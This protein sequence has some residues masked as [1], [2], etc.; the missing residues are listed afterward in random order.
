MQKPQNNR[1]V[2]TDWAAGPPQLLAVML[3]LA[4]LLGWLWECRAA[5]PGHPGRVTT[6]VPVLF[7]VASAAS[8]LL[9]TSF[10]RLVRR[11]V[12]GC[13]R[14]GEALR[15]SC[16]EL[17]REASHL[18]AALEEHASVAITDLDGRI[19]YVNDK[20]CAISRYLREELIGQDHRIINSGHHPHEFMRQMWDTILSGKVWK[21]E[22]RNRAKDGSYY[23][24]AT[25]IVPLLG[26]DNKPNQFVAIRTDITERKQ[27]QLAVETIS[28]RLR[29]ATQGSGIG[30][31][32][33]DLN[34]GA[35]LWD[36]IMYRLYGFKEGNF[37]M[38]HTAWQNA[39][40]PDDL[41][42][43]LNELIQSLY[44]QKPYDTSFRVVWPDGSVHHIR[45][46]AIIQRDQAGKPIRMTGANWD[47]TDH[48]LAEE[49]LA[50]SLHEKEV[51]LKEIHHRVKNN[52]QVVFS[53]LNLQ[54]EQLTDPVA[55]K[56][57]R[58]SQNRVKSMALLH[59]RLYQT[60]NLSR[61]DF[62][63]YLGSLLD[64]LFN[65]FGSDAAHIK[66]VID[67]PGVSLDLE[68]AIPCGLI[69]NELVSNAL[70][71]AFTGRAHGQ[72]AL[73]VNSDAAG[74]YH[75]RVRDDGVGLPKD[76]DFRKTKS[77]G[78]RL[79]GILASQLHGTLEYRNCTGSEFHI[80]FQA[81]QHKQTDK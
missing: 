9:F 58:E 53:L 2:A 3:G 54:S 78:L 27:A 72:V 33:W 57:F 63:A 28:E 39:L 65:S 7:G 75:L 79:V 38:V 43:A 30:I 42:P 24:E 64:Y 41:E 31:W 20:F 37:P 44:E 55:L 56:A 62:A 48:W 47:F 13:L 60:E 23:W 19:T 50:A 26:A 52:M 77:L 51:L 66:R 10:G 46:H 34:T 16:E 6:L 40:H 25:T 29:L 69:V 5:L 74:Q 45:A 81:R 21:G 4:G 15:Q 49:M 76:F 17:K 36:D 73:Q 14:A 32:D 12:A 67:A 11:K 68:A 59:E 71:Y 18:K 8:L 80:A 70:K 35:F 1:Q 22:V 61:I